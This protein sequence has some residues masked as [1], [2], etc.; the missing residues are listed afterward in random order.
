MRFENESLQYF[1]SIYKQSFANTLQKVG[2]ICVTRVLATLS[3]DSLLQ[4]SM[5]SNK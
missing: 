3:P 1:E 2:E 4:Y 5:V